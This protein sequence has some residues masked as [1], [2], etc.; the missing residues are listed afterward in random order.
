M[1]F[2]TLFM[3]DLYIMLAYE[4]FTDM[5]PIWEK[6]STPEEGKTD[7]KFAQGTR[8]RYGCKM[9]GCSVVG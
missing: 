9:L 8:V 4:F 1:L 3:C 2:Y 5:K 7:Y 6:S